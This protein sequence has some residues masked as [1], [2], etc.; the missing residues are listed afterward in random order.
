MAQL[1]K[2]S[3]RAIKVAAVGMN[4]LLISTRITNVISVLSSVSRVHLYTIFVSVHL[5]NE[6]CMQYG[7]VDVYVGE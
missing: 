3:S 1:A 4:C 2:V 7:Y 6:G 5:D